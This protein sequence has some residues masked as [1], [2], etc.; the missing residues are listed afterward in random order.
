MDQHTSQ[1]PFG[2]GDDSLTQY[3]DN[4]RGNQWATFANKR[5]EVID[6]ITIDGMFRKLVGDAV[7]PRPF[8][9]ANFLL[10]SHSAYLAACGTVMAGQLHDTWALLRVC[11][12]QGGYA[13]YVGADDERWARWMARHDARSRTQ[14]DKWKDEFTHGKVSRNIMAAHAGL[15][16]VYNVLYDR[17]IDYGAHPNER[18]TS[19]AM[20]VEETE[21]AGLRFNAVY[22][23]GHGLLQDFVLKTTAQV[24]ICVLRIAQVIYPL[25]SQA[26]GVQFQLETIARRF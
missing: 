3:L 12:E 5:S 8:L 14:Q 1:P 22:L 11:L 6:L 24:G 20:T 15:G 10:R 18:G 9:P 16:E 7:N 13:H 21:D 26:T 2:W 17:T 19:V 4:C 23:H 25:R